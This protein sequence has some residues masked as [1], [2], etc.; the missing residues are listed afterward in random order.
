METNIVKAYG[1]E[2]AN[3]PL[4]GMNIKRRELLP[5]DIGNGSSLLRYL[6]FR[7]TSD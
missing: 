3:K 2:A 7:F 6:P 4:H 1:T 5:H